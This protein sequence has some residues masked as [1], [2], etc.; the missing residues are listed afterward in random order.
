VLGDEEE[1]CLGGDVGMR[2]GGYAPEKMIGSSF[3]KAYVDAL[4]FFL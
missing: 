3:G 2:L 4:F 1:E